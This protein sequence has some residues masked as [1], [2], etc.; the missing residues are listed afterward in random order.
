[1][2]LINPGVNKVDVREV[3]CARS[4]YLPNFVLGSTK[5]QKTSLQNSFSVG[6]ITQF[7]HVFTASLTRFQDGYME[8]R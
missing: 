8:S 7:L 6:R 1:M 2:A 5:G 3:I 4:Q